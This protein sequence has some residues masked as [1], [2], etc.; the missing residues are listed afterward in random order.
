MNGTFQRRLVKEMRFANINT[1]AEANVFLKEVFIPKFTKQFAV[2]PKKSADLHKKL[3]DKQLKD[4]DSVMS[5]WSKRAIQHDYTVRFKNN[6]YQLA[7]IQPTTVYKTDQVTIEEHLNGEIKIC[8]KGKGLD[9][10]QLPARP[11]KVIDIKLALISLH[12]SKGHVPPASHPWKQSYLA[13][14][15]LSLALAGK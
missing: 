7:Q 12:K 9:Y 5:V 10:F 6:Y 13:K 1:I 11:K 2:E 4:L 14:R 3:N 8:L 15:S